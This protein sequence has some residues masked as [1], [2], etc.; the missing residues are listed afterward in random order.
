MN[1]K[2]EDGSSSDSE[3]GPKVDVEYIHILSDSEEEE[4]NDGD[5]AGER[6]ARV[7]G[8]GFPIR[9]ERREHVERTGKANTGGER[10]TKKGHDESGLKKGS[11][12]T[13][14]KAKEKDVQFLQEERK[15]KGVY[16]D[17][18]SDKPQSKLTPLLQFR[19][20]ER[21]EML[22]QFFSCSQ[23]GTHR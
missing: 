14:G 21:K 11:G 9:I 18:D 13:K 15:W 7:I 22:I 17:E 20:F 1:I 12:T 10:S 19:V 8:G 4:Y 23:S 16:D 6:K 3:G 2:E 5:A